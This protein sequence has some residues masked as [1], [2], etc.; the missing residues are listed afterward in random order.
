MRSK[1]KKEKWLRHIYGITNQEFFFIARRV[2]KSDA[3]AEEIIQ[4]VYVK[5]LEQADYYEKK[6]DE[7]LLKLGIVMVKHACYNMLQKRQ[8]HREVSVME[9]TELPAEETEGLEE[10][11][12]KEEAELVD[13]AIEALSEAEKA[14]VILKY[15][16]DMSYREIAETLGIREKTVE[17]RLRRAKNHIKEVLL[18]EGYSRE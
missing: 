7:E 9:I 1:R 12:K 6:S 17:V 2:L 11:L 8:S 3:E 18:D 14:V 16:H 10:L 5:W 15:Y 4:D 13:R